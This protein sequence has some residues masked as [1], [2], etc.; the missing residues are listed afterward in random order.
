[1]ETSKKH[2]DKTSQAV[3]VE[4]EE[5]KVEDNPLLFLF[6]VSQVEEILPEF[7]IRSVPFAPD[8]LDGICSWRGLVL[9][10]V[11]LDKR[12]G[13]EQTVSPE[14]QRYMVVRSGG[15]DQDGGVDLV[16]CV[17]RVSD[18]IKII[19][20]TEKSSIVSPQRIGVEPS[21][22]MG[23]YQLEESYYVV[24]DLVSILDNKENELFL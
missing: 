10:V 15:L 14:S 17:F 24:P 8:F 1:M 19:E 21:L 3:V 5:A 12:F 9:P 4:T 23:A 16:R 18:T 11:D 13:F 2:R 6:T 20:V 7:P 22:V